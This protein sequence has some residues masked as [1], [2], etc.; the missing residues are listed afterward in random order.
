MA[1]SGGTLP[2]LD[3]LHRD[4]SL[5]HSFTH[6]DFYFSVCFHF[7]SMNFGLLAATLVVIHAAAVSQKL[8]LPLRA[9]GFKFSLALASCSSCCSHSRYGFS[10]LLQFRRVVIRIHLLAMSFHYHHTFTIG[11]SIHTPSCDLHYF[12]LSLLFC[13]TWD[14]VNYDHFMF[15]D[16]KICVT[17]CCLH[18]QKHSH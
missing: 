9:R 16:A 10:L 13:L 7:R 1:L 4:S 17:P 12:A 5:T 11:P 8:L 3:D 2:K 18:A 6:V 15:F 14:A